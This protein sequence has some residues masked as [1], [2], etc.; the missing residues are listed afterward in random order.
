MLALFH[1]IQRGFGAGASGVTE[2]QNFG[3]PPPMNEV[4]D[5]STEASPELLKF[6][7]LSRITLSACAAG[8]R[9]LPAFVKS[10]KR[11]TAIAPGEYRMLGDRWPRGDLHPSTA[12]SE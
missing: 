11:H 4:M 8:Y 10:F 2:N 7:V 1:S 3:P 12:S 5:A 9:S 6:I